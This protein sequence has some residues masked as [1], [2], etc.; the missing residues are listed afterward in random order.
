MQAA[1]GAAGGR[2]VLV[3]K[4]FHRTDWR[5]SQ[6]AQLGGDVLVAFKAMLDVIAALKFKGPLQPEVLTDM[7]VDRYVGWPIYR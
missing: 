6:V 1:L 7:T 4:A 2:I 5:M 3:A